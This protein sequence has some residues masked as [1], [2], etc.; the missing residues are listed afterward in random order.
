MLVV[1]SLYVATGQ[2]SGMLHKPEQLI[3]AL[4]GANLG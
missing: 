3:G 2:S 4:T 1:Y